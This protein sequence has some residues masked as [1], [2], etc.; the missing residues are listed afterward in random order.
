MVLPIGAFALASLGMAFV[1]EAL[2]LARHDDD[3]RGTEQLAPPAD[4]D[5]VERSQ[6]APP[7]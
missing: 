1:F 5:D 7:V 3:A 6:V 4:S 2:M